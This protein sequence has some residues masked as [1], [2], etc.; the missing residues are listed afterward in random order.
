[1]ADVIANDDPPNIRARITWN[2][3]AALDPAAT[4]VEVMLY[5]QDTDRHMVHCVATTRLA[6]ALV[7]SVGETIKTYLKAVFAAIALYAFLPRQA[8][9]AMLTEHGVLT[10]DDIAKLRASL[11]SPLKSLSGLVSHQEWPKPRLTLYISQP[12]ASVGTKC[13]G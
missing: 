1:M 7:D 10:G 13:G 3:P 4:D 9:D 2:Y 5:K 6:T 12:E 8:I 11:S